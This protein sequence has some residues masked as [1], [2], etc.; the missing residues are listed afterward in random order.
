MQIDIP[1]KMNLPIELLGL[2]AGLITMS[3]QIPQIYQSI[4]TRSTYDVSLGLYL[5]LFT[6]VSFWIAYGYFTNN[7]TVLIMNAILN[8]SVLAMIILKLKYGMKKPSKE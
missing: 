6:G 3:A 1:R 2:V 5:I 4:K 7:T 8:I